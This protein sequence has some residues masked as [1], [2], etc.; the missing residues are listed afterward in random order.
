MKVLIIE[1]EK[2]AADHLSGLIGKFDNSIE[3]ITRLD[4]VKNTVNWFNSNPHPDLAFFHL[5][6]ILRI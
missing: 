1:D 2:L 5:H 4:S 6:L 3:I